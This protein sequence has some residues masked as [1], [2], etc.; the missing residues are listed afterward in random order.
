M[1]SE[2]IKTISKY[3]AKKNQVQK[4]DV[5]LSHIIIQSNNKI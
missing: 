2:K 4:I 3:L 5:F 1:N